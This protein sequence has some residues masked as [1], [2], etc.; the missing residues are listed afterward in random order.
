M[1]TEEIKAAYRNALKEK[2]TVRRY[3]GAGTNRPRFD[4]TV[5]GKARLFDAKELV[6]AITQGD[7][8][9]LLLVEDL[10]ARGFTLPLTTNDKVVIAGK[11]IAI[12]A[13]NTRKAE[14][15]TVVAYD[16]QARG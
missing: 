12:V 9:V 1:N 16:C 14:D 2:I 7:Q 6:G 4:V 3:T 10:I 5:R 13:P 11:E 8:Q 15:G